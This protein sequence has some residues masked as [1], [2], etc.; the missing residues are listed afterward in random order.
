MSIECTLLCSAGLSLRYNGQTLLIA[1]SNILTE[2][3]LVMK[4]RFDPVKDVKPVTMVGRANMVLVAA[5][6]VPANDVKGLIGH[7][8][9]V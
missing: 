3:P 2:V 1:A 8:K 6:S 5:S 7:L 4:T 9:T